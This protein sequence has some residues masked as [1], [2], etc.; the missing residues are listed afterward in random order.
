VL[1]A[2]KPLLGEMTD[3]PNALKTSPGQY[4][5]RA[6]LVRR[7]AETMSNVEIRNLLLGIAVQFEQLADG[8]ER[9]RRGCWGTTGDAGMKE[10]SFEGVIEAEV[11]K[12]AEDWIK[13]KPGIRITNTRITTLAAGPTRPIRSPDGWTIIVEYEGGSN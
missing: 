2:F 9:P 4:R 5:E 12:L 10:K 11:Q 1:N 13:T 3:N 7:Q 6:K 8:I